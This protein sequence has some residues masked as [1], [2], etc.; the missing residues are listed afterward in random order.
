MYA[1]KWFGKIEVYQQDGKL[2]IRALRSPKLNGELQHVENDTFAVKWEYQDMNADAL[3]TFIKNKTGVANRM[4]INGISPNIDFSF[5]FHDLDP[6][7]VLE[8]KVIRC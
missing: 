4:K 6:V 1:D 3:V 8:S 5:D 7:R 2:Y